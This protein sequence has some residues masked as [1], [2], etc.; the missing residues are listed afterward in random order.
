MARPQE[1]SLGA[2][3]VAAVSDLYATRREDG[4]PAQ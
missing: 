1:E 4:F 2:A 3:L